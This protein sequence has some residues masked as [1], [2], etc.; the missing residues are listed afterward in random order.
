M[1]PIS[2]SALDTPIF[3]IYTQHTHT[4]VQFPTY[5]RHFP[6]DNDQTSDIP[7]IILIFFLHSHSHNHLLTT[8][9]IHGVQ[10]IQSHPIMAAHRV[11]D[12][13]NRAFLVA[14]T[15]THDIHSNRN[16]THT[17]THT[18]LK[19]PKDNSTSPPVKNE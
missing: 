19:K 10:N 1:Q 14:H 8:F 12:H 16:H 6:R 4:H 11:R 15:H 3:E 7:L 5:P 2:N 9:I 13:P 18:L 17:A